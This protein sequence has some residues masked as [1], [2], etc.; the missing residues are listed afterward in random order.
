[1]KP[2]VF[3]STIEGVKTPGACSA[4]AKELFKDEKMDSD[5]GI[6]QSK[7]SASISNKVRGGDPVGHELPTAASHGGHRGSSSAAWSPASASALHLRVGHPADTH[8][9]KAS[10]RMETFSASCSIGYADAEVRH[11]TQQAASI[12]ELEGNGPEGNPS[13]PKL[14]GKNNKNVCKNK[15][16]TTA[17]FQISEIRENEEIGKSEV[18]KEGKMAEKSATVPAK[19]HEELTQI[20]KAAISAEKSGDKNTE[21]SNRVKKR[22]KIGKKANKT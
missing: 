6:E 4:A 18:A 12:S 7:A 9:V 15:G 2:D 1:M 13:G 21:V 16:A 11:T 8:S 3:Q 19:W 22:N 5:V 14:S 17:N 10:P 20:G